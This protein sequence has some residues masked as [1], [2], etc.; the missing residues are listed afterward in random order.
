MGSDLDVLIVRPEEVPENQWE[1]QKY[2]SGLNLRK[3]IGNAVSWFDI[4]LA[5]LKSAKKAS[6]PIFSE[7]EKDGISICCIR[8]GE[9]STS[10]DHS[11]TVALLTKVNPRLAQKL[12]TLLGSKTTS[13]YG[14]TFIGIETLKSCLR[15][16]DQL[17]ERAMVE[18]SG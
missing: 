10:S 4:S 14:E 8:L 6:E 12:A 16:M 13:H 5:E 7:W 9:R 18:I 1:E 2:L 11:D 15:A 17:V 3:K